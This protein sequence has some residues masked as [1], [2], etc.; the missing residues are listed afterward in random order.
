MALKEEYAQNYWQLANLITGFAIAEV[1]ATLFAIGNSP[2]FAKGIRDWRP[3]VVLLTAMA[4]FF[5]TGAVYFCRRQELKLLPAN[6]PEIREGTGAV[7]AARATVIIVSGAL[8]IFIT[9]AIP[10]LEACSIGHCQGRR[11]RGLA[12][13]EPSIYSDVLP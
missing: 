4:H 5:Y 10:P 7:F 6:E 2:A 11:S 3:V 1:L 8:L 13:S 9:L 12:A